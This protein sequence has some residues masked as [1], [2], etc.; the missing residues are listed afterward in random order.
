[1]RRKS[2]PVFD[3][4]ATLALIQDEPGCQVLRALLPEAVMSSVNLAEVLS[5]LVRDGMAACEASAALRALHL[6]VVPFTSADAEHSVAYTAKGV[7][8]GDRCFLATALQGEGWTSDR[9][10]AQ[11]VSGAPTLRYFR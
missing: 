1:M 4:S 10:L 7:S 2:R 9:E 6:E 3:A 8:P 5:K 11:F